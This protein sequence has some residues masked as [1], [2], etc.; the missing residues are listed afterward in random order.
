MNDRDASHDDLNNGGGLVR[1][2][3]LPLDTLRPADEREG[4]SLRTTT[5]HKRTNHSK[6][7]DY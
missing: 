5:A 7:N 2:L 6:I 4:R 3:T 1:P